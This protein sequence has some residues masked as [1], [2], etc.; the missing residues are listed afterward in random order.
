M[1]S[2]QLSGIPCKEVATEKTNQEKVGA[3]QMSAIMSGI[4]WKEELNEKTKQDKERSHKACMADL[5]PTAQ[6]P[7]ASEPTSAGQDGVDAAFDRW[8]AS[9]GNI[10]GRGRGRA[11]DTL[12]GSLRDASR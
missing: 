2:V 4:P 10:G 6:P 12:R 8:F 3:A 1:G 5:R 9:R 7:S 11:R